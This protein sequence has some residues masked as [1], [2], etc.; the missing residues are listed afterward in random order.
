MLRW[1]DAVGMR[2]DQTRPVRY[3]LGDEQRI[4]DFVESQLP[5]VGL[6]TK[7]WDFS[8]SYSRRLAAW[9]R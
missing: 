9:A 4:R 6:L 2:T 7:G 8:G 3:A 1:R 5:G